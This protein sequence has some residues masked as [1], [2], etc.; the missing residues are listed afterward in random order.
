MSHFP[1]TDFSKAVLKRF[2]SVNHQARHINQRRR[3]TDNPDAPTF[4]IQGSL[5]GLRDT[6]KHF[7]TFR[8]PNRAH[9]PR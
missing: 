6:Q 9:V 2:S 4:V 8:V 5:H 1:D 7:I 3:T